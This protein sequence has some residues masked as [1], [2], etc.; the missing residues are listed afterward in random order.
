MSQSESLNE[1]RKI[2]SDWGLSEAQESAL[3][4]ADDSQRLERIACVVSVYKSLNIIFPT[5]ERASAWVHKPND[6]FGG[7]TALEVMLGGGLS[8]VKTYLKGHVQ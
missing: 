1:F 2:S 4:G 5:S 3:L 8:E 6:Y 7:K